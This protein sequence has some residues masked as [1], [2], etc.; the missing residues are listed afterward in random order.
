MPLAP[1]RSCHP[2]PRVRPLCEPAALWLRSL[3]LARA[4]RRRAEE[5]ERTSRGLWRPLAAA[6]CRA[7]C[8]AAPQP[9][10][11]HSWPRSYPQLHAGLKQ[12]SKPKLVRDS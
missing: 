9:L 3:W 5:P 12:A 11:Q 6:R 2:P 10:V 7:G 1:L 4:R 8:R